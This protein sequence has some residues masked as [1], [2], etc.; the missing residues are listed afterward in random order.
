[1]NRNEE[2]QE[3]VNE[4]ESTPP[5]LE[6]AV[7][8]AKARAKKATRIHRLI[9]IPFGSVAALFAAFVLMVN[10]SAP[11]ALA[12]EKLPFLRELAAAVAFS[13][14]LT[15]A[16][17]NQ[18]I[19]PAGQEQ[20]IG[21][22]TLRV[23][24]VIVDEKQLNIFYTLQSPIYRSMSDFAVISTPDDYSRH[25]SLIPSH[26]ADSPSG[27]LRHIKVDFFNADVPNEVVFHCDVQGINFQIPL[28]LD[29][30]ET[31]A[32]ET[33]ALNGPFTLDGPKITS[34]A[35]EIYPT[36]MRLNLQLD[37]AN[38][39]WLKDLRFYCEN[40]AGE[41]F[42]RDEILRRTSGIQK[43]SH[44]LESPFFSKSQSLTLYITSVTWHEKEMGL[45]KIDLKSGTAENL[46]EGVTFNKAVPKENG[47]EL[48]FNAVE[49]EQELTYDIFDRTYYDGKG[50]QY[51]VFRQWFVDSYYDEKTGMNVRMEEGIRQ[52]CF[53][54]E[55]Y[56][57][58]TV[59]LS[60]YF[61]RNTEFA[62]PVIIKV[63]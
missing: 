16:V 27:A 43:E 25:F 58:D 20:T 47:W 53:T 55:N 8:R 40:E 50:G 18:Y 3:L 57:Y 52:L 39:E 30:I 49:R 51:N 28:A 44:I 26:D 19:Q 42:E 15:K 17:E 61:S 10:L 2:Y 29:E 60:P 46:P 45:S 54:L 24:Y 6:Y 5:A 9:A 63:K 37:P 7:T 41:R 14:S 59:Y 12:M 31:R 36:H 56:P 22:I 11:F 62:E 23:E 4:L 1:M 21:G 35:I 48:T 38:T 13:P 33:I 34:A 32:A